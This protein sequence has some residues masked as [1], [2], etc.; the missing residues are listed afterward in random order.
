MQTAGYCRLFINVWSPNRERIK[1]NSFG[2]N[3]ALLPFPFSASS[4][5][6]S[7]IYLRNVQVLIRY[8]WAISFREITFKY[9][10]INN[11]NFVINK[12]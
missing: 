7:S 2:V 10:Q 9:K 1:S 5:T 8:I 4:G 11:I 3:R 6:C 12:V